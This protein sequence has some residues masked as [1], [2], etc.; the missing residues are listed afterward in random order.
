VP[1][2][3]GIGISSVAA[4][5]VESLRRAT[6]P[7]AFGPPDTPRGRYLDLVF[8]E[9]D[10]VK[11]V[12]YRRTVDYRGNPVELRLDVYRPAGDTATSRPAIVWMHGGWFKGGSG[13]GGMPEY[14]EGVARRGY[15]IIA[16]G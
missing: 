1:S 15:V 11:D 16:P 9:V 13:G 3:S 5:D 4:E 7:L 2:V 6:V 8:G 14:A 10:V 12:V